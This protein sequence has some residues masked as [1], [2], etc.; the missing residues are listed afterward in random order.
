M[1]FQTCGCIAA[2]SL[3]LLFTPYKTTWLTAISSHCLTAVSSKISVFNSKQQHTAK[4]LLS[5]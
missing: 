5:T 4:R 2:D 1:I 3:W